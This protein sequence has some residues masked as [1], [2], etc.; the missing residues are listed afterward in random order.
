MVVR[1]QQ[2][3]PL[4]LTAVGSVFALKGDLNGPTDF[5]QWLTHKQYILMRKWHF[6]RRTV[7][8][9]LQYVERRQIEQGGIH[10][11]PVVSFTTWCG[12]RRSTAALLQQRRPWRSG[13]A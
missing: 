12:V 11:C 8:N 3:L 4:T 5:A 9:Q 10:A 1:L 6:G 2:E 13:G 7:G